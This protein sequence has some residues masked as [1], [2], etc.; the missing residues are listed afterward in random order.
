MT[1]DEMTTTDLVNALTL[2]PG[3]VDKFGIAR[4]RTP[5]PEL[6]ATLEQEVKLLGFSVTTLEPSET[7]HKQH[8]VVAWGIVRR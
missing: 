4:W 7:W 2:V 6:A 8:A 3:E 1:N 5:H